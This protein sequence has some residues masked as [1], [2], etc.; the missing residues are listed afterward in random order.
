MFNDNPY[1]TKAAEIIAEKLGK[2][3]SQNQIELAYMINEWGRANQMVATPENYYRLFCQFNENRRLCA[4]MLEVAPGAEG[5]AG[6]I[7]NNLISA[8]NPH[9]GL[10][11]DEG[12]RM[13]YEYCYSR[14]GAIPI[15]PWEPNLREL[16]AAAAALNQYPGA[17]DAANELYASIQRNVIDARQACLW[18][19]RNSAV[20]RRVHEL[21]WLLCGC[22]REAPATL[23][24]IVVLCNKLVDEFGDQIYSPDVS[25][26]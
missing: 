26:I 1:W 6:L 18:A 3:L 22:S 20:A 23:A 25:N 15:D 5:S 16:H 17:E 14:M 9:Y 2:P 10:I 7:L 19:Y 13:I 21:T 11:T 8:M 24:N 12:C 4:Y